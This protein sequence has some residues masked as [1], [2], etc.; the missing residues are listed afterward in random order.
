MNNNLIKAA[1][2]S[3]PERLKPVGKE[4]RNRFR[5]YTSSIRL[6]PSFIIIGAQRAGTTSLFKY[7]CQHPNLVS[8][9]GK[10]IHFF[11]LNYEKGLSWYRSRFPVKNRSFLPE[12]RKARNDLITGEAS[13]Y[14]I[15]HPLVPERIKRHFPE[16]KLIVLLRNPV[17]RAYSHYDHQRRQ[18]RESLSFEEAIEKEESRL[19]GE[20]EKIHEKENYS[21][22]AYRRFS[23]IKRG[24]YANQLESWF[25][26]FPR[27]QILVIWSEEF[28]SEPQAKLNSAFTFINQPEAEID[29]E[30]KYNQGEYEPMSGST[31]EKLREHFEPHNRRLESLL[32]RELPW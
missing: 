12:I 3:M 28:F 23:Y 30:K 7:M 14:Y 15:F 16:I 2:S 6:L 19:S 5:C 21:S 24:E 27:E 22:F 25:D 32:N 8:P 20:K 29:V 1:K 17:D 11:D 10:E 18:G 4:L 13:P 9:L 31:R 26:L